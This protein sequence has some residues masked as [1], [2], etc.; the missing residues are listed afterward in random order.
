MFRNK[1]S[2]RSRGDCRQILGGAGCSLI[3]GGGGGFCGVL[4]LLL[5]LA[6][7]LGVDSELAQLSE[8]LDL[9]VLLGDLL[10][11]D[12]DLLGG[13]GDHMLGDVLLGRLSGLEL[14]GG[15]VV[16]LSLLGLV[17]ASGEED[18]LALVTLKSLCVQLEG[19]L[20]EGV[21]SGVDGDA[22]GL[23]EGGGELGLLELRQSEASSVS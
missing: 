18:Q 21:S 14:V 7:V 5:S 16:D 11:G 17:S 4:G 23:G 12:S 10:G 13:L 20:G 1:L 9:S 8:D 15:G 2:L 19:L 3:L 6:E 22:H